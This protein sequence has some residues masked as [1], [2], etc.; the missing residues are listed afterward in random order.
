MSGYSESA[1]AG[2]AARAR[3]GF[4]VHL[5]AYVLVN[6]VLVGLNLATHPDRLWVQWPLLGWG[7]GVLAHA[8]AAFALAG[9][10]SRP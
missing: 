6:A 5:T 4:Y 2:K 3:A 7:V 9:R 10:R 8:V 1:R